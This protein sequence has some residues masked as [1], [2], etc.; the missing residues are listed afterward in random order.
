M[1]HLYPRTCPE[2][3]RAFIDQPSYAGHIGGHRSHRGRSD[4]FACPYCEKPQEL[5]A[6][7][8]SFSGHI[9]NHERRQGKETET[10]T[11]RHDIAC[12]VCGK[13][14][15]TIQTRAGHIVGAHHHRIEGAPSKPKADRPEKEPAAAAGPEVSWE[16]IMAAVPDE[17]TLADLLLDGLLGR[18]TELAA[19]AQ[20]RQKN[21]Q[22]LEGEVRTLVRL[23]DD[24]RLEGEKAM[25]ELIDAKPALS[26]ALA[27]N[28]RLTDEMAKLRDEINTRQL[29][30]RRFTLDSLAGIIG[31]ERPQ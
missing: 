29:R 27:E 7:R 19:L 26:A 20:T 22:Q 8:A 17:E 30:R 25:L 11:T 24:A 28:A 23:R 2:C 6:H 5:F 31:K 18:I 16:D 15:P 1:T 21:A 13:Q 4:L 3:S 10:T 14:F 12:H 9:R